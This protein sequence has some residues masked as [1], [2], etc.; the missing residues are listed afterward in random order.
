MRG[1]L[2]EKA[3]ILS[4]KARTLY[5]QQKFWEA[6]TLMDE[7]IRLDPGKSAYFLLL[8][9][10]QVHI[11]SLRRSAELNLTKAIDLDPWNADAFTGLGLLFHE[12]GL[13][14]RAEGFYKKALSINPEH[15]I[16]RKRLSLLV[17]PGK[18]KRSSLFGRRKK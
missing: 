8:G 14:N 18:K 7:V 10:A 1:N 12:E 5:N 11:P 4:Q 2:K 3:R 6:S 13:N 15:K 17:E 16:A 9:M